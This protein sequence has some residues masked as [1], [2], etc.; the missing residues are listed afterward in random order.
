MR[1]KQDIAY[2]NDVAISCFVY[3]QTEKYYTKQR[4]TRK[5]IKNS[6]YFSCISIKLWIYYII[7]GGI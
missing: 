1:K 6:N 5:I 2:R 7:Q 3:V 4:N